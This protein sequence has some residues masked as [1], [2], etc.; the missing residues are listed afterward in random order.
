MLTDAQV[1]S[2]QLSKS[3]IAAGT[4]AN[5]QRCRVVSGKLLSNSFVEDFQSSI[6]FNKAKVRLH[7]YCTVRG[8]YSFETRQYREELPCSSYV[9]ILIDE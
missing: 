3:S 5:S 4:P 9:R 1:S 7:H 8:V 6:L 2:V